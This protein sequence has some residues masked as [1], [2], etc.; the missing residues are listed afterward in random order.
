[1]EQKDWDTAR[2]LLAPGVR[3]AATHTG[4]YP[5]PTDLTGADDY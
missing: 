4:S 1:V 3:V 2:G 5:P